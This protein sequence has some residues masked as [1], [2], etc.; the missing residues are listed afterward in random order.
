MTPDC[1]SPRV[2]WSHHFLGKTLAQFCHCVVLWEE[3]EEE[4]GWTPEDRLPRLR[5]LSMTPWEKKKKQPFE[6]KTLHVQEKRKGSVISFL[7]SYAHKM[8]FFLIWSEISSFRTGKKDLPAGTI[9]P[10]CTWHL[11][12]QQGRR[13]EADLPS[14]SSP[15][16]SVASPAALHESALTTGL[17]GWT[18]T[19]NQQKHLA[20]KGSLFCSG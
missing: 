17:C 6:Q 18:S 9:L 19:Q 10:W 13:S 4:E 5:A 2:G 1:G 7:H 20:H 15:F 8:F 3:V 11:Q 16:D 14:V 12:W